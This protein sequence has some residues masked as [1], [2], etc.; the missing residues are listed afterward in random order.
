[1][2]S[3]LAAIDDAE[4]AAL[5]A[6]G[7]TGRG[8]GGTHAVLEVAG[9]LVFAKAV[10]VS[11][12]ELLVRETR[13]TAN[14]F[15]LPPTCQYNVGSPGFNVWRELATHERTTAWVLDGDEVAFPLLYHWRLL[16][17]SSYEVQP[18]H[19]DVAAVVASFG[20][21]GSV[22]RRL[23]AVAASRWSLLLF[24][25]HVPWNLEDWLG[26][27]LCGDAA[28]VDGAVELVG[29]RLLP[30]VR[31]MNERGVFHFDSHLRNVLTDGSD[32]RIS[33]FGLAT[34]PT[35]DLSAAER[36]FL[37]AHLLHDPAYTISRVVNHLVTALS[38]VVDPTAPDYA[39]RNAYIRRCAAGE[40]PAA[41]PASAAA[42]VGRFAPLVVVMNDFS[43]EL[44][45]DGPPPPFPVD[46]VAAAAGAVGLLDDLS[47][48]RRNGSE[49]A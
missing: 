6:R 5:V 14:L 35:F 48:V 40:E 11:E 41:L 16:P 28:A 19:A 25:E 44:F 49:G 12:P 43:W 23:A 13:S 2:S 21:D 32:V 36:A 3:T 8:I 15:G 38:G 17:G 42:F 7:R 22:E 27:E 47:T 18:E 46:E 30:A 33:D 1:M 9:S 31:S 20:G 29:Q 24:L 26:R 45:A 4:L 34:S 10:P 39:A 37:D